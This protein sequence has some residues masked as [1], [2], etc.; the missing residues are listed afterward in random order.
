MTLVSGIVDDALVL[1]EVL[2][3][4]AKAQDVFVFEEVATRVTVDII[5]R[6]VL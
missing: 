3:E 5:G 2:A 1:M 6:V 4:H